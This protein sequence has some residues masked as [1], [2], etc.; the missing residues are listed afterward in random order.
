LSGETP[1]FLPKLI[2][3]DLRSRRRDAGSNPQL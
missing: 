2:K 3:L 1:P